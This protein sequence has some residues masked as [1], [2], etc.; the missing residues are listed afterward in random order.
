MSNE[1]P[2]ATVATSALGGKTAPSP[3][4]GPLGSCWTRPAG[5]AMAWSISASRATTLTQ[6]RL[7]QSARRGCGGPKVLMARFDQP[8]TGCLTTD[9]IGRACSPLRRNL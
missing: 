1:A 4:G 5:T 9:S 6:E 8:K 3:P 7:I 2:N